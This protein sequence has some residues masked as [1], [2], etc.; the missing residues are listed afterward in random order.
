MRAEFEKLRETEANPID[1][2]EDSDDLKIALLNELQALNPHAIE[3]FEKKMDE[4]FS[5]FK[6]G[7]NYNY[8]KD[9]KEAFS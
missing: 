6:E 5:V 8:V 1:G 9:L 4:E 3:D 7:N 2:I